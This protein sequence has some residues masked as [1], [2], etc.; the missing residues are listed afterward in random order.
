MLAGAKYNEKVDVWS[1]GILYHYLLVGFF[2]FD[3]KTGHEVMH[4]IQLNL[5]NFYGRRYRKL[6]LKT[7]KIMKYMLAKDPDDRWS[8]TDLR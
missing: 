2:P 4:N 5:V 7:M 3:G 6:D 8:A 1:I